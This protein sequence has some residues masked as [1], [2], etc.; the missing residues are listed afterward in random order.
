MTHLL[1]RTYYLSGTQM[2][3]AGQL[4]VESH[5]PAHATLANYLSANN[6][7][8]DGLVANPFDENLDERLKEIDPQ[9]PTA[10]HQVKDVI[11][12]ILAGEYQLS[13]QDHAPRFS[14]SDKIRPKSIKRV[15]IHARGCTAARL[16]QGAQ[17]AGLQAVLVASD[18][19]MESKPVKQLGEDDRL[20]CI[21]GNTPQESYLNAMSVIRVA[22]QEEVDAIHPGIGFLSESPRYARICREH[23]F[24]FV[25]PRADNMDRMGNKS[26]AIATA[27]NLNIPVVPG[28]EGALTDPNHAASVAQELSLIHI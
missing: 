3:F 7:S 22:E 12:R 10:Q 19:D 15:L 4:V 6:E 16:V 11:A 24:N 1:V 20:V 26:N 25:G 21:G 14:R 27:K 8:M 23:G 17:Q 5:L 9:I 28:S 2:P 18:P 13:I